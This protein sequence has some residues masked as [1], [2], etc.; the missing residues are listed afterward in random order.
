MPPAHN[1]ER[2]EHTASLLDNASSSLVNDAK[3]KA[4]ASEKGVTG[5]M[6]T[7][8]YKAERVWN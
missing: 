3:A 5:T 6:T 7:T 2:Y 8:L 1:T 4:D